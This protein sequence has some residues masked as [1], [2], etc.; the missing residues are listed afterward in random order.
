MELGKEK[1]LFACTSV[2]SFAHSPARPSPRTF[3]SNL[4]G[5]SLYNHFLFLYPLR[6]FDIIIIIIIL[7]LHLNLIIIIIINAAGQY[8]TA[9]C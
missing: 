4:Y 5:N 6:S 9:D 2:R 1:Q 3:P 8:S 7:F